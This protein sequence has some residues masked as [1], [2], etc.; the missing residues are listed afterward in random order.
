MKG[1]KQSNLMQNNGALLF[2]KQ[3]PQ[4]HLTLWVRRG[5]QLRCAIIERRTVREDVHVRS[6]RTLFVHA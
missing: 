5:N 3:I 4:L 6:Q 2:T 1:D